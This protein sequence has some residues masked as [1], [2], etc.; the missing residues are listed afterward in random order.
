MQ[1]RAISTKEISELLSLEVIGNNIEING[2]NYFDYSSEYKRILSYVADYSYVEKFEIKSHVKAI[3]TK[4]EIYQKHFKDSHYTCLLS[5]NPVSDFFYLHN[6][7]AEKTEFY[8][9]D[10]KPFSIGNNCSIH[11]SAIIYNN[12]I[13]G[14][15]VIVH[16]NVVIY[17]QTIIGNNVTIRANSVIGLEG[18]NFSMIN[19]NR[20]DIMHVG[21]V[22]I[23]NNVT[24]G[25]SVTIDANVFEGYCLI[26]D[27]VRIG[28]QSHIAPVCRINNNVTIGGNSFI[29]GSVTIHENTYL[30]PNVAVRN[31]TTIGKNCIVGMSSNVLKNIPSDEIWAGNP[32][33]K[34]RMNI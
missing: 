24:I 22:K 5:A 30:A 15:N 8:S 6:Y 19:G 26:G 23:G 11:N 34:L 7:L 10:K 13:M 1:R 32:S 16:P 2:L 12:V 21:G 4:E 14:D 20:T 18:N 31:K 33:K 3:I 9:F 27:N 28:Q 25:A 17:P 29:F